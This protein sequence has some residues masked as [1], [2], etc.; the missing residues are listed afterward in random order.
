MVTI[1]TKDLVG[2]TYLKVSEEDGQCF[3]ACVGCAIVEDE[4]EPKQG[5]ECMKFIREN[6]TGD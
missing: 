4:N 3:P 2:H 5:S 1:D 6:N